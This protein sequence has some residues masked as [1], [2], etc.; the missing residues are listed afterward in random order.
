MTLTRG[1]HPRDW[2]WFM[3]ENVPLMIAWLP[4]TEARMAIISTGQC[5][6]SVSKTNKRKVLD[7]VFFFSMEE[8]FENKGKKIL[9]W[10]R[11]VESNRVSR[12]VML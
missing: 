1:K 5:T 6:H 3:I 9:T 7:S 12:V 10:H 11:D 8:T 2:L 4:T